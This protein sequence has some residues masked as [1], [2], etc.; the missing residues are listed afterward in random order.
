MFKPRYDAFVP[1]AVFDSNPYSTGSTLLNKFL[2]S[3]C[4]E[5]FYDSSIQLAFR[6]FD[7]YSTGSTLFLIDPKT[8]LWK[9]ASSSLFIT[10]R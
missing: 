2:G 5:P 1:L 4:S 9:E 8:F 3:K 6:D 10:L 7:S